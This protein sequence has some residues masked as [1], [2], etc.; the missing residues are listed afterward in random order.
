MRRR[1][2]LLPTAK[3]ATQIYGRSDGCCWSA[4]TV[5][6]VNDNLNRW[7]DAE[8]NA[9]LSQS[10]RRGS[11][12]R[13][14]SADDPKRAVEP[15]LRKGAIVMYQGETATIREIDGAEAQVEFDGGDTEWVP[16]DKL[17]IP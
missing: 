2:G 12:T 4:L 6:S 8:R 13:T 15:P 16:L 1:S 17:T 7:C 3:M 10:T 9:P 11:A 5:F 14:S